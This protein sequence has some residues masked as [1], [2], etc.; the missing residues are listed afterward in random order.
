LANLA[1]VDMVIDADT[2]R[3]LEILPAAGSRGRTLWDLVDRTRS[4]P[5]ADHLRRALTEPPSD[6]DA[7]LA[8]QHAHR[9]LASALPEVRALLDAAAA[10][11]IERYLGSTWHLP[12]AH[13]AGARLAFAGVWAPAWFQ[14]Y[15]R[16]VAEGQARIASALTAAADLAGRLAATDAPL[17]RALGAELVSGLDDADV[18]EVRRLAPR[19]SRRAR[20]AFDQLARSRAVPKIRAIL[21]GLGRLEASWCL[22]A[23]TAER[24]WCFPVPAAGFTVHGLAHPLLPGPAVPNDLALDVETRVGFVT[25]PNMAG[26]ST[27]LK[28]VGVAMVLAH[29]GCGVPA[30]AMTFAPAGIVFSSLQVADDLGRGESFYLAEVR[31]VKALAEALRRHGSILA[32]VDEPFRG[33][34]VHDAAEATI[35]VVTSLARQRGA[36]VF[37]A[38][39]LAE[40]VPAIAADPHVRLL[41]FAADVR[42][43]AVTFDY[44]VREGLSTQRLGMVLLKREG[45]LELLESPEIVSR[46]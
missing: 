35:A 20:L 37:V 16:A 6:I 36:L 22:A 13:P 25:G 30:A 27:F 23:V 32:V 5:G 31:R 2:L 26:K 7:I 1:H 38:S 29:A 8:R 4:R 28:A 24:G 15:E 18:V 3:D 10:D 12:E 17:L 42:D 45:V 46:S 41:H 21:D 34:N 44:L 33:T 19:T 14:D 9:A 39:H 11:A 40:V 43:T